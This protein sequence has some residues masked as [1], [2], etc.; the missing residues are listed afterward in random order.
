MLE[1]LQPKHPDASSGSDALLQRH[2]L[3]EQ[4]PNHLSTRHCR[5]WS[6]TVE[7]KELR[8]ETIG[9]TSWRAHTFGNQTM[10]GI[11]WN[12][13]KF[14]KASTSCIMRNAKNLSTVRNAQL[15]AKANLNELSWNLFWDS[16]AEENCEHVPAGYEMIAEQENGLG[17]V[18]WY[19]SK[20]NMG[21]QFSNFGKTKDIG[22]SS[23]NRLQKSF[24]THPS[25]HFAG[26]VYLLQMTEANASVPIYGIS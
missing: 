10:D 17:C 5:T 21:K 3:A 4:F 23:L 6:E 19:C 12:E 13:I 1:N 26:R 14:V 7:S 22:A 2:R 8:K 18:G 25:Q 11:F 16:G 15:L 24:R 20:P 9:W